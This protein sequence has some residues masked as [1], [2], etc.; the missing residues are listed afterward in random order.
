MKA[1]PFLL[2]AA[3][4]FWGWQSGMPWVGVIAG[5]VLEAALVLKWRWDLADVDFSRI[6]S[7]CA[8]VTVMLAG[9]VFT[10]NEKNAGLA[11]LLG[12]ASVHNLSE[13]SSLA[14]TTFLRWLPAAFLPF[15][16]AQAYNVRASVPLTAV[17]LVLRWRQRR[18]ARGFEGW[19][20]NVSYPYFMICVFAAG[21]HA[22]RGT[23]TCFW[24]P[25]VLILWALWTLRPRR[26]GIRTYASVLVLVI[27]AG[28]LGQVGISQAAR[29]VQD[30]DARWMARFFSSRTDPTQ[31]VTAI[32]QI[33]NLELSPRIVIRLQPKEVGVVP[34]YLRE[35]SYRIYSARNQ[36]WYAGGS[37]NDFQSVSAE[38]DTTTWVLLPGKAAASVNIACYLN[39]RSRDG[40][41]EGVLPLPTGCR[42]LENLPAISSVIA[43]Q[44][45]QTGAV[46]ATGLGLMMFDA[47]YGPGATLGSPPDTGTNRL[48]LTVPTNEI[49]ALKQVIAEMKINTK[50]EDQILQA[51]KIFF[52]GNF[53][54]S[55][56]QG[57]DKLATNA[58]PLTRFLLNS[59]N[60]HCE[61]F[62]TATVLLLRQLGIPARYA[63]GYAVHETSG[64]GYVVRERDAHAWCLAWNR[65]AKA[66]EDF[67]TTP[68]S[69]IAVEGRRA[70]FTDR[71]SDIKSWIVFQI[72][73][74]RWRQTQLRQYILW[75]LVPVMAVLLYYIIFR[76]KSKPR[77]AIKI[78]AVESAPGWPGLDSAFYRLEKKLASRGLS[79]QRSEPVSN[80]L[81]RVLAEP[82][83]AGLK[84]TLRELLRL[85]YRYRF[86]P[87]G[88]D[89]SE[90]RLMME[91]VNCVFEALS[92]SGR[93]DPA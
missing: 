70:S 18:G 51:V 74:F 33:G 49:P 65:R 8:L 39:G 82:A 60:G 38:P 2:L 84:A 63:V 56:W 52:I 9:Y 88:L 3:L 41:P 66:W 57:P 27:A 87:A 26:F 35:A 67:D 11:G 30:F 10:T 29:L 73:K 62:A 89:D 5:V 61:Y 16:A 15:M 76:R 12:R 93:S 92:K 85:H 50:D 58:T 55:T 80:W 78:A 69:W 4:T 24:G 1:P 13:S 7:F 64:S 6:W 19:Y 77:S 21:I 22:N 34:D 68:A 83:L 79:R 86:D 54:Y 36:T 37:R 31:S 75:T 46:L 32:G 91:K 53:T 81:E 48:D 72:E 20:L 45:N 42:R 17:S 14:A 40:D 28:F 59:R 44:T 43:L 23:Q 25:A 71:I 90:K 47:C